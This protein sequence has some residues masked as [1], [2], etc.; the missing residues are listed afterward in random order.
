M[1]LLTE[2]HIELIAQRVA[3]QVSNTS[4]ANDLVDH[5]CCTI[6]EQM[7]NG[8][9]EI[10]EELFFLLTLKKQ[11]NMK[12][13]VLISGLLSAIIFCMGIVF[14]FMHWPGASMGIVLGAVLL[15]FVFLPLILLLKIREKQ[16]VME[17][18][19]VGFSALAGVLVCMSV[20]FLVQHWPGAIMLG[21][22]AVAVLIFMFVPT[23]IISSVNNAQK[24]LNTI[25]TTVFVIT[26]S[27]LWLTLVASPRSVSTRN[28]KDTQN[29]LR[30]ERILRNEQ[31]YVSSFLFSKQ[32]NSTVGLDK[33]IYNSIEWLK[34]TIIEKET[35]LKSIDENVNNMG[36]LDKT[37]FPLILKDK[38]TD[39]YFATD[40]DGRK[41]IE[42]LKYAVA[43]YNERNVHV[44]AELQPL[45]TS[46][47]ILDYNGDKAIS[48][49]NDC[50][51]MQMIIL[52]NQR[53]L[54][55]L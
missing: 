48:V 32:S 39:N 14:K 8:M 37:K 5:Y 22:G 50:I 31:K 55:A 2:E 25:A 36:S 11:T 18:L 6:E 51:Q 27:C 52:Q 21:Y 10:Q 3:Q 20:I 38:W 34:A 44:S 12:R 19:L 54:A 47:S 24:R 42:E 30:N 4:L 16:T 41:K 23:N 45:P 43:E 33:K 26:G 9:Q 40:V 1:E 53:T 7:A 35:G 13:L 46:L 15:S 49:L 29:F 28:A 17:K